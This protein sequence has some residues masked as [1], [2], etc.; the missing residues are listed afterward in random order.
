MI[1]M[2]ATH[3]IRPQQELSDQLWDFTPLQ[4]P[5]A[6]QTR[7]VFVPG[8]WENL[9]GLRSYRGQGRYVRRFT[10]GGNLRIVCKGVSHTADVFLDGVKIAHHYNAYTPF[11]AVVPGVA[12][13][14][15]TL[16]I[17]AD[18][19]F[20]PGSALHIP[21]DYMTYGGVTRPVALE[22][23]G[24]CFLAWVHY[25]PLREGGRWRCRIEAAVTG[26]TAGAPVSV[27]VSLAGRQAVLGTVQPAPGETATVSGQLDFAG[28]DIR[29]WQPG[30][31]ALYEAVATLTA[32]GRPVDDL[33]DRVGFRAIR[34]EGGRI[35][36]NGKALRIRGVCRHE[37]LE[38]AGC[39][40][41]PAQMQRD[42]DLVRD[43]G[44]NSVRTT[45]YPNDERFLDLCDEQGILVWE[46]NH[47]RGL[48]E[49]AMRN[50]NFAPQCEAVN[51]EM[52][53]AHYNH[54]CIYIWGILNECASE[55]EYGRQC[56][57][58]QLAQLRA[59]DPSR[60]L[61]FATCRFR[62]DPDG[63][64]FQLD[65]IC[66]DLPDVVACNIYPLWYFDG[67][68]AQ[69][70]HRLEAAIAVGPGAGKPLII[71]E[72]G[73]GGIYGCHA[74]P[75][76]KWTEEY[77]AE[78]LTRQ[79][80]AVLADPG[81]AGVYIWQFADTRVSREW[82]AN[83]PRSYNNKGLLDEYRRP[84]LAYAAVKRLF[85]ADAGPRR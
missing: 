64:S 56:Y 28:C 45:H 74:N 50:P 7:P 43:L 61:T 3:K 22:T 17:L 73:A 77:Q 29:P 31:P 14:E 12:D 49:A 33:I 34:V 84:K 4:G 67:D 69:F 24:A 2:F 25:T 48:D 9:P 8:C 27:E 18:N 37:D 10:G 63:G 21:N 38:G 58:A 85:T 16:E 42:L 53:A 68:V 78:A 82:F 15:H 51:A 19:R 60:P 65:D 40:L 83:R 52:V 75:E 30:A 36:L 35:L 32:E 66:L 76:E 46:E 13:G 23:V 11:A 57:A 1:R 41:A 55:T 79:L 5:Q 47:A 6:G 44:G 70:L 80:S 71:S 39:A 62:H 20:G 81:C 26:V 59:L 72:I 54:P